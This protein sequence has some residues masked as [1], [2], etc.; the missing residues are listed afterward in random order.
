MCILLSH[1]DMGIFICATMH[2]ISLSSVQHLS[3]CYHE[4]HLAVLSPAPFLSATM[5]IISRSS[6]QHPSS[7]HHVHNPAVTSR[8]GNLSFV[9]SC[10][11]Y[12]CPQ[13]YSIF[14]SCYH[15]NILQRDEQ[16]QKTRTLD[17]A[18]ASRM[19]L[20]GLY[21]FPRLHP[22]KSPKTSSRCRI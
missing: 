7:C 18:L 3:S 9:Q 22:V 8:H 10:A 13:Q 19:P 20:P 1:L 4:H 21:Y 12:R 2:I 5:H 15:A 17:T 16:S 6:V 11:S 14:P